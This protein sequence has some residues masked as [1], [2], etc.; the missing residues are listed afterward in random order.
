VILPFFTGSDRDS[1]GIQVFSNGGRAQL[2]K[3]TIWQL[4]SAWQ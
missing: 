2:D 4:Q 1:Q 3:I